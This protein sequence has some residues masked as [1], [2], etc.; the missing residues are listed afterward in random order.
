MVSIAAATTDAVAPV[1]IYK[2]V[3]FMGMNL[4]PYRSPVVQVSIVGLVIFFTVGMS[5]ALSGT[6]GGGQMDAKASDNANVAIYA[7]FCVLAFFGGTICNRIGVRLT[8][9]WAALAT[10][11]TWLLSWLIITSTVELIPLSLLL[12]PLKG[13]VQGYCG[14]PMAPSSCLTPQ[15]K[16]KVSSLPCAGQSSILAPS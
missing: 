16:T 15:K 7:T 1:G 10:H 3:R 2:T 13:S 8:L 4:P 11:Y 5:S 9:L 12:A 14:L 6:G